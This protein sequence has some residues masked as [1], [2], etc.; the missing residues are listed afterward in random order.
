MVI[1]NKQWLLK[2]VLA[3]DPTPMKSRVRLLGL[4]PTREV[5]ERSKMH[6]IGLTILVGP[7]TRFDALTEALPVLGDP[8]ERF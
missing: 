4:T 1:D 8:L 3:Y 5:L 2:T 7:I 6:R